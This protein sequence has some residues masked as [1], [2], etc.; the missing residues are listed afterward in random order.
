MSEP[1][2]DTKAQTTYTPPS[3]RV[4][5]RVAVRLEALESQVAAYETR[6]NDLLREN[7]SLQQ[8]L[9]AERERSASLERDLEASQRSRGDDG[10]S[11]QRHLWGEGWLQMDPRTKTLADGTQKTYRYWVY[12]YIEDGQHKTEYIGSGRKL[13]EWKDAHRE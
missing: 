3:P 4:M 8:L 2:S 12:H 7:E 9:E 11:Y 10:H 13:M 1:K 6:I 5:Q